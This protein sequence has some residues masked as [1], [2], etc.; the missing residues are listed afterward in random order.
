MNRA[1]PIETPR[2]SKALP[3]TPITDRAKPIETPRKGFRG[4][5]IISCREVKN[6]GTTTNDSKI[7]L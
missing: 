7:N 5:I 3:V 1:K 2:K 6:N 4:I